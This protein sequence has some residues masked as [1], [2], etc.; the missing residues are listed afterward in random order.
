VSYSPLSKE[1]LEYLHDLETDPDHI[2]TTA[3]EQVELAEWREVRHRLAELTVNLREG[4]VVD[5]PLQLVD[6]A[7]NQNRERVEDEL[8]DYYTRQQLEGV[9]SLVHRTLQ[10]S[11]LQSMRVPSKQTRAYLREATRTYIFG[12]PLASIA[13]SRAA[14]EQA[15]KDR[16]ERQGQGIYLSMSQLIQEA[17]E[18]SYLDKVHR[19]WAHEVARAGDLVLHEKPATAEQAFEVLTKLR[20]VLAYV[21]TATGKQR[22]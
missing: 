9:P 3:D 2:A 17:Y 4:L 13:L 14:L 8:D 18:Y 19:K 20:G 10:F 11:P 12:L 1:L 7:L 16:L 6:E 22:T 15:L 5:E 21:F